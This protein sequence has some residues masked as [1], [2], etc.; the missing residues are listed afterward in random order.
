[1]SVLPTVFGTT[2]TPTGAAAVDARVAKGDG[3]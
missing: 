3:R 1:M 2:A